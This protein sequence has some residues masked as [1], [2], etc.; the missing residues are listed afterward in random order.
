MAEARA[1]AGADAAALL[2]PGP[3]G[4]VE[5]LARD[6]D[7][8]VPVDPAD[9]AAVAGGGA[10][11]L[12]GHVA[13]AAVADPPC[14]LAV[15]RRSGAPFGAG[16]LDR[17]QGLAAQASVALARSRLV[18]DLRREQ[19]ERRAL[20]AAIVSAQED[21]RRRVAEDIHDGPVQGLSAVGLML[22]ALVVRLR[23]DAP[24]AVGEATAAAAAAR[25]AVRELRRAISDLHPMALGELG[26]AAATR[27]LVERLEWRGIAVEV[28]VGAAD[29]LPET[30]RTVAFRVLQE[31][32]AN[33]L[34]HSGAGR[35]AIAARAE[36]G[37][38]VVEVRD[39]G[40]GLAPGDRRRR[41]AEGH[42]G[43]AAIEER[44]ALAGG[45]L[46]VVSGEGRG[47][48]LRLTLPAGEGG[49]QP[50]AP[51]T[52]ASA[53]DSASSSGTGAPPPPDRPSPGARAPARRT[54]RRTPPAR[55]RR[56]GW[57]PRGG[58]RGGGRPSLRAR[59]SA[60][61]TDMPR[62]TTCSATRMRRAGPSA[63]RIARPWPSL[64]VPSAIIAWTVS[65]SSSSRTRFEIAGRLRPRRSASSPCPW[66]KSSMSVAHA[67]ATSIGVRSSRTRFSTSAISRRSRASTAR[68]TTG[69]RSE[70]GEP[71]GPPAAL[72]GDEHVRPGRVGRRDDDRLDHAGRPDGGG[73]RLQGGVL[74]AARGAGR[75]WGRSRRGA[76]RRC[77]RRRER[78]PARRR[79][80]GTPARGPGRDGRGRRAQPR[81]A[82]SFAASK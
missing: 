38:V 17:L 50:G 40:R 60:A 29:A 61:R 74:D 49:A 65:G 36:G 44:A 4:A 71:R 53:A 15:A 81:A 20:A 48:L 55:G 59:A 78:G 69:T 18:D 75:G 41:V 67:T 9:V 56:P 25:E 52:R 16:D 82:T 37:D 62:A 77:R 3:A 32:V 39:D 1:L 72:A 2:V 5:E 7:A 22:D 63:M 80:A 12:A 45:R 13:L 24:D 76:A 68:T 43:L 26:L 66:P 30:A 14:A 34:R 8:P 21:E 73:Q 70:A 51:P 58:G 79:R 27:A 46:D 11:R 57:A 35:V 6:G 28:D 54:R 23:D 19:A 47:T 42:L 33:I 64:S 10:P 31:A